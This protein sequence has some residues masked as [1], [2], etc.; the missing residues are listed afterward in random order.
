MKNNLLPGFLSILLISIGVQALAQPMTPDA[1]D[2]LV[3]NT[4][5][6]FE[7]PGIAVSVIKD[8]KVVLCKGYGVR[9]LDTGKPVDEHTLFGIAS[10]SKAF[11]CAALGMLVDEGKL[12]WDDRVI[13]YLPEFRL[14]DP[15]VTNDFRIKD[16][17]TH[18]SGMGLG[19]GDLMMWPDGSD[20]TREDVIRN[21]RHLKQVSPFRSKYDYDNNLYIVAGEVVSKVSG[22]SWE[23]FIRTRIMDP[24]GMQESA[25]SFN[26][27]RDTSNVIAPH[28]S[29]DGKVR[30][31]PRTT[32]EL[33][34]AAGGLYANL[35]DLN[36]W[37]ITLLNKGVYG[38]DKKTLISSKIHKDLWSPVTL[39]PVTT[40]P[41]YQ[42]HFAAYGLGFRLAD[43]KGYLE[44]SHTGGM[45][46]MVTQI[47]MYPELSL[48][49]IVLTNQQVSAAFSAI[50]NQIK[51][52][53]L[54]I[55]GTDW[56]KTLGE[57]SAQSNADAEKIV[58][59]VWAQVKKTEAERA[60]AP[61]ALSPF[62][63]TYRDP[64]FGE[65]YIEIRDNALWFKSKRSPLV[66]GQ[67]F[68]YKGNTFVAKW[69][70]R[71][72]DADAFVMFQ[73]DFEGKP[74]GIRM[75]PISPQTDFSYDFQD[76]E[77]VR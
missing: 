35:I 10:N 74:S 58:S 20:F 14:Y 75:K 3:A 50:S 61:I 60:L 40:A 54:G 19:A 77:F 43:V 57:R 31:I 2:R 46:G 27:L 37:V 67:L 71:T 38:P 21:L 52:G 25:P 41:P 33:M 13:D 42:S 12:R 16:L 69:N 39:M 4:L 36:K 59:E 68:P 66:Y 24:L 34:N 29:V 55:T 62:T 64:W 65:V 11:T 26:L 7:V 23:Q 48:G 72:M 17:L 44:V 45:A 5:K 8:G 22:I 15:Y 53:Y 9:S 51:D 1:I 32:G 30:V 73:T 56:V 70:D 6:T 76:L 47:I 18:R 63:G 49:I 28:G